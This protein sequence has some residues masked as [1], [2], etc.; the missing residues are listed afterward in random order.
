MH[1][2]KPIVDLLPETIILLADIADFVVCIS[3]REPC[4][5]FALIETIY[6][7][8]EYL[9]CSTLSGETIYILSE[10]LL[11]S[12]LSGGIRLQPSI[13]C[14]P[15]LARLQLT[16]CYPAA[17]PLRSTLSGERTAVYLLL[18]TLSN[19]ITL[20]STIFCAST[21]H[22]TLPCLARLQ[23]TLCWTLLYLNDYSTI[24]FLLCSTL[25]G[26]ILSDPFHSV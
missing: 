4:Q 10:Y 12:T 13:C 19:G 21:V 5:A 18:C 15:Y 24:N 25:S 8:S 23:L 6:I 22:C 17:S 11:C 3:T 9:L 14:T 26:E 2:S 1:K 20:K 7:L 16:L